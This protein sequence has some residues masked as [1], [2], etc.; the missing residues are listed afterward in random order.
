M[1]NQVC[2]ASTIMEPC[3]DRSTIMTDI[4]RNPKIMD[5]TLRDGS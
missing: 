4:G 5:C 1:F 2:H 3:L